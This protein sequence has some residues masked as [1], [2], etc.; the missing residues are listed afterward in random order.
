MRYKGTLKNRIFR[1]RHGETISPNS[2]YLYNDIRYY[3]IRYADTLYAY[4]VGDPSTKY[5]VFS[6]D[7]KPSEKGAIIAEKLIKE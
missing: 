4:K 3:L 6:E 5:L 1:D 2:V 7:N